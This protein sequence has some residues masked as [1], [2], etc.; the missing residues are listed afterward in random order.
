MKH[1]HRTKRSGE[2][3]FYMGMASVGEK[4]GL[5]RLREL[6][7]RQNLHQSRPESNEESQTQNQKSVTLRPTLWRSSR[8]IHIQIME[9]SPK[10]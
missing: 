10:W 2:S 9:Q 7:A 8:E 4:R 5:H 6:L 1:H 3:C